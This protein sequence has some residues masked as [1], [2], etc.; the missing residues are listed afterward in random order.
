LWLLGA[1][2]IF[3][4]SATATRR[5]IGLRIQED[6]VNVAADARE[7]HLYRIEWTETLTVFMID[8]RVILGTRLA[9]CPPLGLIIWIDNQFAG[10]DP[11]GRLS[12]GVEACATESWLEIEDPTLGN[13]ATSSAK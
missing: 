5:K 11:Q 3:P 4:F 12:W 9:P 7:W 1:A 6:A 8:G 2:L 10:F 13:T